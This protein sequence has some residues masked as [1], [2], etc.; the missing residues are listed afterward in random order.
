MKLTVAF[1]AVVLI[2]HRKEGRL[3]RPIYNHAPIHGV[4]P[5]TLEKPL[6]PG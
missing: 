3:Q 4:Q 2:Q 5:A 6:T 1:F